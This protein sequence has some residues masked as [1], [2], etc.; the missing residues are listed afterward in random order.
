MSADNRVPEFEPPQACVNRAVKTVLPDSV[1]ITKEAR[2]A[3]TRA[4]GVFIFY[5]THCANDICKENKRQTLHASDVLSAL[6]ELDFE[7]FEKPL[8]EFLEQYRKEID[9]NKKSSGP[10]SKKANSK[11]LSDGAV[12]EDNGGHETKSGLD[13]EA[14]NGDEDEDEDEAEVDLEGDLLDDVDGDEEG[15]SEDQENVDY[16]GITDDT[17]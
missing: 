14:V 16:L 4:A 8:E 6:R 12:G 15:E 17:A 7:D 11:G 5:L 2:A 9:A 10:K 13:S 1:Q 3:F